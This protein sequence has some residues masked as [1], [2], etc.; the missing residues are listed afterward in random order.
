[1]IDKV[2]DSINV[3]LSNKQMYAFFMLLSGIF[4]G[5]TLQPVPDWLNNIFN[6]SQ[7]FKYI[8]I[9]IVGLTVAYPIDKTE[10]TA[11]IIM[12]AIILVMFKL[13]RIKIEKYLDQTIER[14]LDQKIEN[15]NV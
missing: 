14:K 6:T 10:F 12:A 8:V 3:I 1:M 15:K 5:Y 4:L 2:I 11:I 7:L 13:M 9:I